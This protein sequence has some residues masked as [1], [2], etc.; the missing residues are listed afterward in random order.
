MQ[1]V[2]AVAELELGSDAGRL[3]LSFS[4]YDPAYPRSGETR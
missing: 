1:E 2:E 4:F 3:P